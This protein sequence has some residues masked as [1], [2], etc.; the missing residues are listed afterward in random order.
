MSKNI[1][2]ALTGAGISKSS[3]IPTFQEFPDVIDKLSVDYKKS[4]PKE[5]NETMEILKKNCSAKSPTKAH[6]AL[7]EYKIPIITMNIDGFHQVAGSEYVLDIHG[8]VEKDD[9]VLY[10]QEIHFSEDS[11]KLLYKLSAFCK[12]YGNDGVFIII[13]TSMQTQFANYLADMAVHFY[14]LR[15]ESITENADALVPG[16]LKSINMEYQQI[17]FDE[18]FNY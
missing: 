3:G 9:V 15:I 17:F 4:H 5:F 1:A 2:V 13:G 12:K 14:N 8:S 7:A 18:I 10:G 11:V 16:F 6:F